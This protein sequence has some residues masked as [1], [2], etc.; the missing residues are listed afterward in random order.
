MAIGHYVSTLVLI[1]RK[2]IEGAR[3][4]HTVTVD[5]PINKSDSL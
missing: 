5:Y 2:A 3:P 1:Q 4:C